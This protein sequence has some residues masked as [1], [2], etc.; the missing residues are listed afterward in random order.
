MQF[1]TCRIAYG[2]VWEKR[3]LVI[4]AC[5]LAAGTAWTVNGLLHIDESQDIFSDN[6]VG[7]GVVTI[8]IS[9]F[10]LFRSRKRTQT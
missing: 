9:A 4:G 6:T 8:I 3:R 1:N 10:V 5:I 7:L 2:I